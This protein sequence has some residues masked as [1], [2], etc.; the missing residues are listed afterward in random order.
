MKFTSGLA[1]L[2]IMSSAL[3]L[4]A[5]APAA[6]SA[7]SASFTVNGRVPATCSFTTTP[8]SVVAI[9]TIAGIYEIGQ[10][11][12]TC[13]FVGSASLV[14]NLP[15]GSVLSSTA[16]GGTS[17]VYDIAWDVSPN[18]SGA[19]GWQSFPAAASIPFSRATAGVIDT[20]ARGA[21]KVRLNANLTVAGHYSSIIS[22]TIS[23]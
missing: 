3:A 6:W 17:V 5:L 9:G 15:H 19:P 8:A 23:P 22:Y 10:L 2:A 11:G 16:N 4:D 14:L 21:L 18:G 1:S 7:E 12:Y 13:N 20:E